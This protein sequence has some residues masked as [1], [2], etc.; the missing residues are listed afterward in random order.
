[1]SK[2]IRVSEYAYDYLKT[3]D[4]KIT[5]NFDE[6]I[7]IH[8]TQ[9]ERFNYFRKRRNIAFNGSRLLSISLLSEAIKKK[10]N[11][12][13]RKETLEHTK[14]S[15][16]DWVKSFPSFFTSAS[17]NHWRG[18]YQKALDFQLYMFTNQY[19]LLKKRESRKILE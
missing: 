18:Q 2:L 4:G 16:Q 8:T 3:L 13:D 5:D 14:K 1:M 6:I 15:L 9:K 11:F 19:G 7:K 12:I 10:D 17:L